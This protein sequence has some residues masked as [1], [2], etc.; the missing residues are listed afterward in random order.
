MK[1]INPFYLSFGKGKKRLE[2]QGKY[3]EVLF[4]K[5]DLGDLTP[6]SSTDD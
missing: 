3:E 4:I 1:N 2:G 6:C 5:G